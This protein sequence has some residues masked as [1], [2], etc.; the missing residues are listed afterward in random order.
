MI[1]CRRSCPPDGTLGHWA[2]FVTLADLDPSLV[3]N[4][5]LTLRLLGFFSFFFLKC[6]FNFWQC[7]LQIQYLRMEFS[8]IQW[9]LAQCCGYWWPGALAAG[10]QELQWW[11]CTHAFPA[12]LGLT[13]YKE[14]WM[15]CNIFEIKPFSKFTQI[16]ITGQHGKIYK[17]NRFKMSN[18]YGH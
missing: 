3:W 10:H 1:C 18:L 6:N 5:I 12:V 11:V 4:T 7:L 9:L 2:T 15:R 8:S 14:F 17:N 16:M 13:F